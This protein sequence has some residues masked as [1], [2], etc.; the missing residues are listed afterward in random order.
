MIPQRIKLAG[1]LSYKEEQAIDFD[2]APLWMLS[3]NNGSGKSSIFDGVTFALFGHHRGGS[4]NIAELINK[5]SSNLSVEFDFLLDKQL[6][7][8]KRTIRRNARGGITSTQQISLK[9]QGQAWEAVPDT[10][11]KTDFN[12]WIAEKI[13]LNYETFTSSVLLL[14][15][16]AE[17]LLD[18]APAGRATV[19]AGI[20]DLQRFQ[21]LHEKA[22]A[23]K[24]DF[25]NKLDAVS[26]RA[27]AIPSVSDAEYVEASLAIERHEELRDIARDKADNA[28]S[29]EEQAR[30]WNETRTR[31]NTQKERLQKA[32][33]LLGES[34]KI[35]KGYARL[36]ELQGVLPVIHTVLTNRGNYKESQ[37]RTDKFSKDQASVREQEDE[38]KN[39]LKQA[40]QKKLSLSK[41]Q[42]H[43][44]Q[45]VVKVNQ[46]LR[47]LQGDLEKV[48]L[49]EQHHAQLQQLKKDRQR[50]PE[51]A[52]H[53][54]LT[55][56]DDVDRLTELQRIHPILTRIDL[57]RHELGET[58]KQFDTQTKE[59]K[60]TKENGLTLKGKQDAATSALQQIIQVKTDAERRV[61]VAQAAQKQAQEALAEFTRLSGETNCT[62]CGQPLTAEHYAEE[63]QRR[64]QAVS[65]SATELQTAQKE[66][67]TITKRH[68]DQLAEEQRLSKEVSQLRDAYRD[69]DKERTQSQANIKKLIAGLNL[70]YAELPNDYAHAIDTKSP[71]DW[72]KTGYPNRDQLSIMRKEIERIPNQKQQLQAFRKAANDARAIDARIHSA[73]EQLEQLQ[74]GITPDELKKLRGEHQELTA[75]E[76]SFRNAIQA[77]KQNLRQCDSD[78]SKLRETLNNAQVH[79]THLRGQLEKEESTQIH[80]TE[81]IV[82]GME[83]LPEAWRF[84]VEDAG[85]SD[86]AKWKTERDDL[87]EAEIETK[88][89]QLE[90]AR[91]G[92][93]IIRESITELQTEVDSFS[94]E[95]KQ[96]TEQAKA[97]VFAARQELDAADKELRDVQQR[98]SLLDT[99]RHQRQA[100]GDEFRKIDG[101]HNKHKILTELLG[102]DRLQRHLV[103]KAERQIVDHANSMLDRLSDGKLF[104]KLVGSDDGTSADKALDLECHNRITGGAPINVAFLS[105]SQ[106]FRVAVSLALAIGQYASR[107]HRPIESVI[108]DEGFGCLDRQGRQV[109]IQELHNLRE[110]LHCILLVSHQEEFAEAFNDGYTFALED[111]ATRVKR[112]SR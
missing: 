101:E 108:I 44:E 78:I 66:L 89:K 45:L 59:L 69:F 57:E 26:H 15:G 18:A 9:P 7:R 52:E 86:Q 58:Q 23:R 3:G 30:R 55:L 48:R 22:N 5:E 49:A 87:L 105:G 67:A 72:T 93:T 80:C 46:R 20:V 61:A 68:A 64:E 24:L 85:L 106:R 37:R 10:S 74:V 83:N 54:V 77:R 111:G 31:L 95:S 104:L 19:L 70:H 76:E 6:Y 16:R 98:K 84:S 50:L 75:N 88:F 33:A 29:L 4:Q 12:S 39:A 103:R 56:Q 82:Q 34:E 112:F 109:M 102:R 38:A 17:K 53:D 35:E 94:D 1:F 73:H 28:L 60:A 90:Q 8:I 71:H 13:S 99:H 36:R 63:Q 100:L 110:H 91:H 40:E 42:E 92:Q 62:A 96:S 107:Q 81:A 32:E 21:K 41:A 43:D 2:T 14:Q 27:D 65:S 47:E 97:N 79:L 11:K 25:K 51:N